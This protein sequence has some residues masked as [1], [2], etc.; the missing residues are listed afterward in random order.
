MINV[1]NM[2]SL[3]FV[4]TLE[5]DANVNCGYNNYTVEASIKVIALYYR[6]FFFY[7]L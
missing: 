4:A 6:A 1:R 5:T 7:F 2:L 3:S